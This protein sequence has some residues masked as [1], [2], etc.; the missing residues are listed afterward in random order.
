MAAPAARPVRVVGFGEAMLR[1]SPTAGAGRGRRRWDCASRALPPS[2]RV[3]CMRTVGGD[4]LNVCVDF[5]RLGRNGQSG[6]SGQSGR[7]G[8]DGEARRQACWVSA[9]PAAPHPL[10]DIV[11][12]VAADAGVDTSLCHG[13]ASP[14]HDLGAFTVLPLQ[15]AVH[16]SRKDSAF[17]RD[18][19]T[20]GYD[21]AGAFAGGGGGGSGGTDVATWLHATGITPLCGPDAVTHWLSH[22]KAAA[23]ANVPVFID[24]NHRPA[25]GT[26]EELWALFTDSVFPSL[27]DNLRFL[28]FSL[29]TLRQ[30][31][32]LSGLPDVPA[33]SA[34]ETSGGVPV[35]QQEHQ[36]GAGS[37]G[38]GG[39][40][41]GGGGGGTIDPCWPDLLER[42]QVHLAAHKG[43]SA[44]T[45][46]GCCFKERQGNVQTRWSVLS[47]GAGKTSS[48]LGTPVIHAPKDECG[49]GSAWAAG[50]IDCVTRFPE[51]SASDLGFV[52]R[53]ADLLAALCQE[54]VGDHSN[55][56][57]AE[58]DA[59]AA[60]YEGTTAHIGECAARQQQA[61]GLPCKEDA[62]RAT[63]AELG[64]SRVL[65][66]VRA[67]NADAAIARGIELVNDLG[68]TAI[69]VTLDTVEFPRVLSALVTAVGHK[70]R[71]GVG[72]VMRA[73]ELTLVARLGATFA[74]SPINPQGFV[75]RCLE[76]GIVPVPAA[77]TPTECWTAFTQGAECVK[78]FPAQLWRP[79]V[80]KAMLGTGALGD[81]KVMPSGGI[82]PETAQSWFDAGAFA[83]GM[84][85]N[86]SGK[87]I[88]VPP[89]ETE[90]LAA[91]QKA[92]AEGGREKAREIIRRC[93]LEA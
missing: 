20:G 39:G 6:R 80:L 32:L 70:A 50:C 67:K 10:A 85:S 56:S 82:S 73:E 18:Q 24:L 12:T 17:W 59:I 79:E 28:M 8:R 14:Q 91:A 51:R 43:L 38:S 19:P 53:R 64:K 61:R 48:T 84:G 26:I 25:L 35:G 75:Q 71:V 9:L 77:F 62:M 83:V 68:A 7:N 87:D 31:A 54:T 60:R 30:C 3:D 36:Q 65:A 55:T 81:M 44:S 37:G 33:A 63:I 72:T 13:S 57:E 49:G 22:L 21:W 15:R 45:V 76:L 74:L 34:F 27:A 29:K 86:L 2:G 23:A 92:W 16:Y 90:Q 41:G 52:A 42:L 5:V 40:S 46:L 89:H 47:R 93:K 88:K 1:Y 69:E 58:Y 66:I 4:E 78:L 11:R